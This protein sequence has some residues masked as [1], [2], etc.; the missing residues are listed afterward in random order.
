MNEELLKNYYNKFNEDKRLTSRHGIVEF[1][2]SIKYILKYLEQF[3][4]PKILDLGAGTGRYSGYLSSLGY[5]VTAVELVKHNYKSITINYPLVKAYLGNALDLSKFSDKSFDLI[6]MFGPIYHLHSTDEKV[7]ALSEAKRILKDNGIIFV[8]YYMNDYAIIKHGFIDGFI[9][10]KENNY[11]SNFKINEDENELY[12]YSRLEDINKL[13]ELVKL[14]RID[15]FTQDLLTDYFRKEINKMDEDTFNKY[16]DYI[17]KVS[18]RKDLIGIG[19][20]IVDIV[21]KR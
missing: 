6:I 9:N 3:S 13:N 5:D 17:F 1:N 19:S 14:E 16:L 11:D 21:K 15:I 7:K 10:K 18:N 4:N 2:T 20:H 8:C 12:S